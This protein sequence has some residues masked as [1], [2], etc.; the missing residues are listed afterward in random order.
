M[1]N[2]KKEEGN[3]YRFLLQKDEEEEQKPIFGYGHWFCV[4]R[5]SCD[6]YG[7]ETKASHQPK[8]HEHAIPRL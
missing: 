3:E 5:G 8:F 4:D 7:N 1:E 2:K 6:S